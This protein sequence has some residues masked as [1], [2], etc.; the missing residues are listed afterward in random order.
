MGLPALLGSPRRERDLAFALIL[1]RVVRPKTKL[2]TK[3]WWDDVTLGAD[4][5]IAGASRDQV[6]AAM[7][8][9]LAQQDHIETSLAARHLGGGAIV[10]FDLSSSW[11][12]GTHCKLGTQ[13]PENANPHET[14]H[15]TTQDHGTSV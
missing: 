5:D 2:A 3:A 1:S 13:T 14:R 7:D 9:L 10:M 12:E 15:S 8:W 4:L 11:V 6:Y